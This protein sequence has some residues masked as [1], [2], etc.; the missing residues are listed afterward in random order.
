M[1]T[2][3]IYLR[4]VLGLVLVDFGTHE[5]KTMQTLRYNSES[6]RNAFASRNYELAKDILRQ[7]SIPGE[8]CGSSSSQ[9]N[10]LLY[11]AIQNCNVPAVK[12]LLQFH[13]N[14]NPTIPV[15]G[16]YLMQALRSIHVSKY[17]QIFGK[18]DSVAQQVRS[19]YKQKI[20]PLLL[21]YGA[22]PNKFDDK[23]SPLGH[24]I[25]LYNK[26]LCDESLITMLLEYGAN[27][28]YLDCLYQT[29]ER[30]NIRLAQL[31]L[32]KGATITATVE[33]IRANLSKTNGIVHAGAVMTYCKDCFEPLTSACI[34]GDPFEVEKVWPSPSSFS[35]FS[36]IKN[37]FSDFRNILALDFHHTKGY[38]MHPLLW[39]ASQGHTDVVK[40]LLDHGVNAHVRDGDDNTA[41]D[42]AIY[43]GHTSC[44]QTIIASG[45]NFN[46]QSWLHAAVRRKDADSIKQLLKDK[47]ELINEQDNIGNT[48]LH[49]AGRQPH[50][51]MLNHLLTDKTDFIILNNQNMSPAQTIFTNPCPGD[52]TKISAMLLAPHLGILGKSEIPAVKSAGSISEICAYLAQFVAQAH[53][54][55]HNNSQIIQE[56]NLSVI[57]TL[58]AL[59]V[60]AKKVESH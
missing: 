30:H 14:A 25:A 17:E 16:R 49:I 46:T 28:N 33:S 34:V 55:K 15:H 7:Q 45:G 3:K 2:R 38:R 57:R 6:L 54:Q 58:K 32:T 19:N 39:A 50:T 40:F 1:F 11:W 52:L 18:S 59:E 23:G 60:T 47:P 9:K 8:E 36:H 44:A 35:T 29:L 43:N 4:L 24:A 12:L 48:P 53:L 10:T 41:A 20:I 22:D 51:P 56:Q 31:L 5:T 26:N 37:L 42:L 27:P 21:K 13:A